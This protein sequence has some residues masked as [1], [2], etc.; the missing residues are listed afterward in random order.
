MGWASGSELAAGVWDAVRDS[1]P[2]K[3]RK[4]I[5]LEIIDLFENHDCDTMYEADTL[6]EDAGRTPEDDE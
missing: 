5:A 2:K 3:K 6:C 1:I 4:A